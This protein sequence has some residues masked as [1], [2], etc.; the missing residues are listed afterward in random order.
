M[1]TEPTDIE[2]GRNARRWLT[3]IVSVCALG[4]LTFFV[5]STSVDSNSNYPFKYGLDL[6]GGS[7]LIYEAD[8][9]D[10]REDEVRELMNVLKDVIERRINIFGVSEPI[11]QVETS[12][13]V[14]GEPRQRLVVEL[15]GVTDVDAAVAEIGRTPLLEF[16]LVNQE[17]L[18]DEQARQILAGEF[19]TEVTSGA[20][21]DAYVDTGLTGRYLERAE[22]VFGQGQGGL[23]NEP[24]VN[25]QFTDAGATLF[26]AITTDNVG[27][28]LAIFLDGEIVS[29][30]RINEPIPGGS[31]VI[32]GNFTATEA[33]D[34]VQN[35]NFGALPLPIELVNTQTI[36]ASLGAEI[37]EKGVYA[38][39]V[40]LGMVMLFML[41]WYRLPGLVASFALLGYL[42]VMLALFKVIPVTLTAAGL[43]GL[44]LSV[45]MAVDANVLVF[46]RLKEEFRNGRSS[47][48]AAQIGF[49]RAWTSIRDGNVTSMFAAIILFWLGTSMVKGFALV[50][51]VGVLVSMI[52]ALLVTRAI[53]L[54]LPDVHKE[55]GSIVARLFGSGTRN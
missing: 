16:K 41:L 20:A 17:A 19:D 50:F 43:A 12:S 2:K 27:E 15:P 30:P 33:R 25:V 18:L 22:L 26:E 35:L 21:G 5:Y 38:G 36:D 37:L 10:V 42:V 53:L 51:G 31:A 32:S 1:Q 28:F 46:E 29:V 55:D 54:I 3:A 4:L 40:G 52:S 49:A 14:S 24:I 23:A 13:F 47:R 44:I 39:V 8:T 11:I 6:A 48:E 45:G 7:Q 9:T 34:L